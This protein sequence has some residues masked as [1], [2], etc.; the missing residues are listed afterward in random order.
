M[1]TYICEHR[2][3]ST[4]KTYESTH[5]HTHAR[6]HIEYENTSAS[7]REYTNQSTH[8]RSHISTHIY[9]NSDHQVRKCAPQR[10]RSPADLS[11][12][13]FSCEMSFK[14]ASQGM[15]VL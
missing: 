14:T 4:P 8:I 7:F 9:E 10:E 3:E 1:R 11:Q 15:N 2:S 5:T 12:P 6:A 13:L